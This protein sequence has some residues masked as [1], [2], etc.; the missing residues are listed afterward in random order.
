M[1]G[2]GVI[3]HI[4]LTVAANEYGW[5][6][7]LRLRIYYDD[8]PDPERGRTGRRLLRRRP[9]VRTLDQLGDGAQQLQRAIAQQL[10]ADAVCQTHPHHGHQRR[11]PP[12]LEPLL[13]RRLAQAAVA[14]RQTRRTFTRDTARPCRRWPASP[15]RS[16]RC[17]S[18]PLRRHSAQHRPERSRL[19]RRGRRALLRRRQPGGRHRRH[20]HRGL[21]QRR[22]ELPRRRLALHGRARRRRHRRRRAAGRVPVARRRSRSRSADRCARHRARR[23]DVQRRRNGALGLR[24]ARGPVQQRRVLVSARHR[25]RSARPA[26]RRRPPADRQR[27][28]DRGRGSAPAR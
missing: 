24:G 5:P 10:L 11:S 16:S 6:R 27:A 8:S 23:L 26:V 4:W 18:G 22:V 28:A 25:G 9:R 13:P 3:N 20:G 17:R 19:V 14:A 21:L 12:R 2:P 7:L 15:T 1:T